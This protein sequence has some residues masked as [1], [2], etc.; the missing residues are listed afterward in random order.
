MI[1][2]KNRKAK[3]AHAGRVARGLVNTEIASCQNLIRF[4]SKNISLILQEILH[5]LKLSSSSVSIVFCDNKFISKLNRKF[6]KKSQSTDVISFPLADESCHGY[7]GEIVIS[8][9]EAKK[10]C[11][12]YEKKWQEELTLYLIHGILHL[13]GYDDIKKKDRM[14][15]EQKQE[16]ILS[17][18]LQ[19][20]K[21]TIYD[22]GS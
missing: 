5:L 8:V 9:E 6:F 18:L 1:K 3:P 7:L 20:Y 11:D 10:V 17:G 13:V 12:F 14:A 2:T 4:N 15:M 22:I 16:K 19:K 21:K